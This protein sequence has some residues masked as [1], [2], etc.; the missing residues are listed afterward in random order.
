MGLNPS[1]IEIE[2]ELRRFEWKVQAGADF[3]ITQPVFDMKSLLGFLERIKHLRIPIIAGLWPLVS[4]RNAEFMNNE[5]PGVSVPIEIM[6]RMQA[7][8]SKEAALAEGIK[9]AQEMLRQLRNEV[10]GIQVSAP[11]GK[12]QHALEVLTAL[13]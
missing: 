6:K 1:A 2:N 13:A 7:A 5:L 9:I 11:F 10:Q 8:K 4:L 3:A 12:V